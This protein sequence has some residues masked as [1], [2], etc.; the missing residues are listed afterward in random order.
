MIKH[1]LLGFLFVVLLNL[2]PAQEQTQVIIR[3]DDIG[4]CH[5]VNLAAKELIETGLPFSASVMFVC[6]WYQE[7][8]DLL[9][10]HPEVSV[11]VHLT[12]NAEWK[13]FRWGP[14]LGQ[15]AVPSLVDSCGY[16]TPSRSLFYKNNPKLEEIEMELRAQIERA[17]QSGLKI[18][19]VDYHMGTAVD[20]IEYRKVV[21]KLAGEFKLGISRY[22]GEEDIMNVYNVKI[23]N[24][25]DSLKNILCNLNG[26]ETGLLVCHIGTVNPELCA[27]TDMNTF[28]LPDMCMHRNAELEALKSISKVKF[29]NIFFLT[30]RQKIAQTRLENM[31][32]PPLSGY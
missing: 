20:K 28:G 32:R 3:C 15:Q 11:G 8:V 4:M 6:P 22:F 16:F 5:S 19:Y 23:E 17:V 9:K 26:T 13:N 7:A 25:A 31:K 18:D 21:E 29:D 1:F 30:Y 14:V 10:N 27:M 24:K 12:L 2:L